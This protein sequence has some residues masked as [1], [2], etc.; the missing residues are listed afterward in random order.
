M[1]KYKG[2]D[3]GRVIFACLIPIL[4]IALPQYT[5]VYIFRQYIARLGVPFFFAV[6]GMFLTKSIEK[7]GAAT[8][9]KKYSIRIGRILIVWLLIYSPIL[10]VEST[11]FPSLIQEIFFKTPAFLWYL[12]SL[13]FAAI[14]FCFIK[15][16]KVLYGSAIM[17]YI[18]GTL[19]GESYKWL[20]GE[21]VRKLAP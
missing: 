4:H 9:W 13:L 21:T 8:A 17:L 7:R 20:I 18:I 10:L 5:V 3:I 1:R 14:P 16:K 15:N 12:S 11:S 19:F 2:I 6:S